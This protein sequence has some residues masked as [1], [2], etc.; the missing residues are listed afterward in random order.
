MD[1]DQRTDRARACL[2]GLAVG[3]AVGTTAEF[4]PRGTFAQVTDMMGGGPF[5]LEPG[6]WTDDTSMAL[7]LAESLIERSGFDARDQMERYC[8]WWREGHFSVRN[9]CF[10]IGTTV[11]AALLKFERFGEPF[12]GSTSPGTA[13]NGSIMR[14]APVPIFCADDLDRAVSW[15]RESSRT[16]HG[17][18]E[19][20]DACAVLGALLHYL[21]IG[22]SKEVAL[23]RLKTLQ[24]ESPRV[25]DV[26]SGSYV[27]KEDR[28]IGSTGYVVHTLEAALWSFERTGNFED[29]ILCAVNLGEDADTTGAV[30][31]QIAGACYGLDGIPGGWLDKLAMRAEIDA[32]AVAL[33][34]GAR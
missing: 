8:R 20:L 15:S 27:G 17:A 26:A 16:T 21:L 23:E 14:L 12:S 10:D 3:D 29:A 31:G 1:D 32:L 9:R 13:G 5:E 4:R 28:L 19:C 6:E 18:M 25:R 11:S 34:R 7:C 24:L 33:T 30:C 2:L 22:L